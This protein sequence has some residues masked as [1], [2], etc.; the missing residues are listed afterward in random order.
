MINTLSDD[1]RLD[2]SVEKINSKEMIILDKNKQFFSHNRKYIDTM[3]KIING[4]SDISIRLLDWFVSNYSKEYNTCYKI[5]INGMKSSFCVYS[6]YKNQ[7]NGYSKD[8]FDPFCRKKKIS[9][10]YKDKNDENKIAFKSSI[11]QLNF[12]QWAIRNRIIIYVQNHIKEIESDMKTRTK[13]NK[14][15][16]IASESDSKKSDKCSDIMEDF[17]SDPVICSSESI[18][19]FCI[20]PTKKSASKSDSEN[21]K[22]KR[23]QLSKSPYDCGIIKSNKKIQL[24][25]DY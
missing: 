5:S 16:K 25:F 14:K 17:G 21:K 22:S 1:F 19:N 4:E 12:F 20:S 18:N 24:E 13:E 23:Q 6:E 7:L 10:L 8:Y 3:L 15:N 2:N 11:G 9:Y